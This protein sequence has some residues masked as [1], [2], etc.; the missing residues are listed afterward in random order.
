MPSKGA[1]TSL[2]AHFTSEFVNKSILK[3]S[4]VFF[5]NDG[6]LT[7]VNSLT[8]LPHQTLKSGTRIV[9]GS[10][11]GGE[12]PGFRSTPSSPMNSLTK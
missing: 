6:N 10:P 5:H 8:C 3:Y 9:L 7:S 2:K 11:G 4:E 12:N 1:T